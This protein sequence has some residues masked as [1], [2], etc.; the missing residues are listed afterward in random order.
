MTT[1]P[2]CAAD[3]PAIA[4]LRD[5]NALRLVPRPPLAATA[6]ILALEA[7]LD[8]GAR[9]RLLG[10]ELPVAASPALAA[11]WHGGAGPPVVTYDPTD[12]TLYLDLDAGADGLAHALARSVVAPVRVLADAAGA[13]VAIEIP[14]RG[15]GYELAYPSGNR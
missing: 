1:P 6:A 14:R 5:R 13:L 4:I 8:V 2:G 11:P 9:G 15:H 3:A 7:T 10:L 12:D